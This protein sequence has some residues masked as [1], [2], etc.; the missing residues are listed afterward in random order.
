MS[1]GAEARL[2]V[3]A[4]RTAMGTMHAEAA[5][6]PMVAPIFPDEPLETKK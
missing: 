6:K 1:F 2:P 5:T 4:R 3:P